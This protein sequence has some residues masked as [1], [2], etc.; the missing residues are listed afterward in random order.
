M[1]KEKTYSRQTIHV[2]G[3]DML[4]R[5]N[6]IRVHAWCYGAWIVRI[7]TVD[8][9]AFHL[10]AEWAG[11]NVSVAVPVAKIES[12]LQCQRIRHDRTGRFAYVAR[13]EL[14]YTMCGQF[15]LIESATGRRR[16]LGNRKV[17]RQVHKVVRHA[18]PLGYV[19]GD[20]LKRP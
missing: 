14:E 15:A 4:V 10:D 18:Q 9:R 19:K 7:D 8:S 17:N 11:T 3:R 13:T 1:S 5:G 16:T 6:A 12:T 2:G 20:L